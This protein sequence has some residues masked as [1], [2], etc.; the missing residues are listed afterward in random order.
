[1]SQNSE[2]QE[3]AEMIWESHRRDDVLS[4]VRENEAAGDTLMVLR[5]LPNWTA[6]EYCRECAGLMN[7]KCFNAM[8]VDCQNLVMYL[9]TRFERDTA[10]GAWKRRWAVLHQLCAGIFIDTRFVHT[11][12]V[13]CEQELMY[14]RQKRDAIDA[15]ME[16][17][18][19]D[20]ELNCWF[21]G[22]P[23][24]NLYLMRGSTHW[25]RVLEIEIRQRAAERNP[26]FAGLHN[27]KLFTVPPKD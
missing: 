2:N 27:L 10:L 16:V 15:N 13:R 3:R 9:R 19:A 1:M 23:Y 11:P 6:E 17:A 26:I 22:K 20:P 8:V 7:V 25:T 5:P 21:F 4:T 18:E 24:T 12:F 14:C